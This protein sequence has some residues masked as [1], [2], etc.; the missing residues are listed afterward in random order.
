MDP[1]IS[2]VELL[3]LTAIL[4]RLLQY[5]GAKAPQLLCGL[6]RLYHPLFEYEGFRRVTDDRFL[7]AVEAADPQFHLEETP[8]LLRD[9]GADVTAVV[10]EDPS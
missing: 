1:I 4:T 7:L 9:L 5:L 3:V 10:R 6:P 8:E 2:L